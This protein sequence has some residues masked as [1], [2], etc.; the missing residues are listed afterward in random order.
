MCKKNLIVNVTSGSMDELKKQLELHGDFRKSYDGYEHTVNSQTGEVL[1]SR[2]YFYELSDNTMVLG[3]LKHLQRV[4][5][6]FEFKIKILPVCSGN[7][8]FD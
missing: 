4:G 5:A 2:L 7:F 1:S 3:M 8:N 6:E